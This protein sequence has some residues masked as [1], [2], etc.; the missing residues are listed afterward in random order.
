M[1]V[2]FDE[3]AVT[4]P[5]SSKPDLYEALSRSSMVR[6]LNAAVIHL[7]CREEDDVGPKM[8]LRYCQDVA[9]PKAE[10]TSMCKQTISPQPGRLSLL[11]DL[12]HRTPSLLS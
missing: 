10:V 6:V 7:L 3:A 5:F 1:S 11:L 4:L 8:R 12:S 9:L 2:E